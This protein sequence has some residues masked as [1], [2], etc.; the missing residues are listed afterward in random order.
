M[1]VG[2]SEV[3]PPGTLKFTMLKLTTGESRRYRWR[4]ESRDRRKGS[5]SQTI[6]RG[7]CHSSW[8][9]NLDVLT[10]WWRQRC[11]VST[12]YVKDCGLHSQ[13]YLYQNF[14]FMFT[15]LTQF[16]NFRDKKIPLELRKNWQAYCMGQGGLHMPTFTH[17]LK[18]T[19]I[20]GMLCSCNS[21][22]YPNQWRHHISTH[23]QFCI[24][25]TF[26]VFRKLTQSEYDL[27]FFLVTGTSRVIHGTR[28]LGK[29]IFVIISLNHT[30][31]LKYPWASFDGSYLESN[32]ALIQALNND[33]NQLLQLI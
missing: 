6:R 18:K 33:M 32:P 4:T 3:L 28:F 13:K 2:R 22:H 14:V 15:W 31:T 1:Q 26:L 11:H 17:T 30:P 8:K 7:A 25:L 10:V 21:E 9:R 19:T 20:L 24:S 23:W 27:T 29:E 5:D 12:M 16:F